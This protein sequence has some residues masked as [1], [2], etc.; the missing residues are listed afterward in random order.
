MAETID[1]LVAVIRVMARAKDLLAEEEERLRD[2]YADAPREDGAR[3]GGPGQ[4][5]HGI[6]DLHS[7]AEESVQRLARAIGFLTAGLDEQADRALR[8]ARFQP[9]CIPSGTDRMARPLGERTV[10]AL[11]LVRDIG[12]FFQGTIGVEIDVCLAAP[13]ATWPPADWEA[14]QRD[15]MRRSES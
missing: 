11:E 13:E 3:A 2:L 9:L 14:Y 8:Q 1:E 6:H 7:S 5:L 4:T 12:H 15:R 10:A